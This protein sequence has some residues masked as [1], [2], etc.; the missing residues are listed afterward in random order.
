MM[1]QAYSF[2]PSWSTAYGL[3]TNKQAQL[4]FSYVTSPIF[5][6]I[7]EQRKDYFALQMEENLPVQ[8]EFMGIP[9]FCRNCELASQFVNFIL[10]HEGQK[11]IMEKNYMFPVVKGLLEKTIFAQALPVKALQKFEVPSMTEIERVLQK[12]SAIRRGSLN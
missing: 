1:E 2:A 4:T 3:F 7:E 9:E 6:E 11:I 5:H 12:W 8:F 10:S